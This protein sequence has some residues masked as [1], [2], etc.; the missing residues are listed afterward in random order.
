M[1]NTELIEYLE[2]FVT[3]KRKELFF[4]IIRHRTRYITVA[5]EDIFQSQNASAVLRTCDCLG[6]QDVHII[7]NYNKYQVNPDVALGA[8]KW[9]SLKKYN[10]KTLDNTEDAIINLKKNGYRIIATSPHK[11]EIDLTNFDL[12]KGKAA[13]LFGNEKQGL[14]K[15]ALAMSDEFVTI[16]MFGFTESY[17]ISVSA[18]ILLYQLII[19]LKISKDI[20]WRVSDEEKNDILLD[21]FMISI[22]NSK[23]IIAKFKAN[24]TVLQ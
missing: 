10:S 11:N 7:E 20:D 14:S 3:D 8:H 24:K 6:I 21:W 17:N 13:F 18:A 16:P 5:M 19:Q 23:G 22:R 15:K 1:T 4:D 12:N 9:L 2:K